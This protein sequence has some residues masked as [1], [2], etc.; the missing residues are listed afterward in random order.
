[1]K[2]TILAEVNSKWKIVGWMVW[3]LGI[4][5]R[6][7]HEREKV[8]VAL[9]A[10]SRWWPV[11][12]FDS[13]SDCAAIKNGVDTLRR[14]PWEYS[15]DSPITILGGWEGGTVD[16]RA[17]IRLWGGLALDTTV[18][19]LAAR[20]WSL[21]EDTQRYSSLRWSKKLGFCILKTKNWLFVVILATYL[22]KG[23]MWPY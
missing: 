4:A 18:D 2:G 21:S 15:D 8:Y 17:L 13:S 9:R 10:L 20:R 16:G 5:K 22:I 23:D 14:A 7:V 11:H 1:M 12:A 3:C 19:W 6:E